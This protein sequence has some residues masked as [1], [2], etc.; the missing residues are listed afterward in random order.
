MVRIEP[1][2]PLAD[3]YATLS[4]ADPKM[5]KILEAGEA[6]TVWLPTTIWIDDETKIAAETRIQ[7]GEILS[8]VTSEPGEAGG[9]KHVWNPPK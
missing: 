6:V 7:V 3:A 2:T 1:G 4:L 5:V 9:A 8:F